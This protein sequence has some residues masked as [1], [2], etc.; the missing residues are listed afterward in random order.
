MFPPVLG[1]IVHFVVAFSEFE[2]VQE[3][4][5]IITFIHA[6]GEVNIWLPPLWSPAGVDGDVTITRPPHDHHMGYRTWHH[7]R[8]H[9]Q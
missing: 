7:L 6:N 9:Q 8:D 2:P 4:A 1:E 5:G 3:R